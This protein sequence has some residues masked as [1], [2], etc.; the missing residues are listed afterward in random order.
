MQWLALCGRHADAAEGFLRWACA[1]QYGGTAWDA[2]PPDRRRAA[3]EN[4]KA[5]LADVRIAIG[6]YPPTQATGHDQ[7]SG[8]RANATRS[9]E[10]MAAITRS[11]APQDPDR[12]RARDR[13][14]RP[15]GRI[16]C[17][18]RLREGDRRI[19]Q[20]E[21]LARPEY[22]FEKQV[23]EAFVPDELPVVFE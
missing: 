4:A 21:I 2:F 3:R 7:L 10:T 14:G 6:D 16:R 5:V 8:H 1:Y 9:N 23:M 12:Q 22:L 17:A 18:G 20:V 11:L 15:R 13:R 19:H